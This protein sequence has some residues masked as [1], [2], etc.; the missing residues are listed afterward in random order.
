[1][2]KRHN[3]R[4]PGISYRLVDETKPD[5]PR[6]YIVWYSDA[7]GDGHTKTLPVG[8]T[9]EDARLLQGN[10]Q[11]RK[12]DGETLVRTK[13]TVSEL[14]EACLDEEARGRYA[15]SLSV[16]DDR[17][18]KRKA[19]DLSASD[20]AKMIAALKREGKKTWTVR[21]VLTPLRGA[22]RRAVRDGL[23]AS[24]PCDKLLPD[25]KP[26][27]DQR[28]MRCLAK[29]EISKLLAAT[30]GKDNRQ[31]NHRWKAL[32]ALLIFGGLRISEALALTWED[33][34]ET[35]II[36]RKG[37]TKAAEREVM[38]IPAVRSL[39]AA[40]RMNQNPGVDFVFGTAPGRSCGRREALRALHATTKR[41]EI[42]SYTLHELRHTF[43][44]ILI[45]Q[46]ELP[47][48]IAKQMGHAD[49]SITMRV[50]AHLFEEQESVDKARQRL[51]ETMS[52]IG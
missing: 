17:I 51:E 23:V 29:D 25:E 4:Y 50:Y 30:M 34:T 39:L 20:V 7:N 27:G 5:G 42:P 10:L 26:K 31:E 1:M 24:N 37:K 6:R 48:L 21:K 38:L 8:A 45:H 14:L 40:W 12:A 47:T 16:L 33:V 13:M 32:F 35:T 41:A 36:V 19:T 52:Q 18:G 15:Y 49:P 44:S 11:A 2:R 46:G 22:Y 9:L 43:A 3:T 28:E